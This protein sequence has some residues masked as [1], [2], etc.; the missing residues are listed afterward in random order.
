MSEKAGRRPIRVLV[1]VPGI[2]CHERAAW[3]ITDVLKRA[4][5]EVIYL[6]CY[7]TPEKIATTAI[8]EDVDVIALSYALDNCYLEYFPRVV[9]LLEEKKAGDI[10]V[11]GGGHIAED[12]KPLLAKMNISGLY[13]P[14][15][16]M[17]EIIRHIQERAGTRG[18][19]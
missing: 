14:G 7:N 4:G 11:V 8:Q 6:G 19:S 12:H 5:M 10:P 15:T 9:K 3:V 18:I 16:P 17:D 1:A 13:G 2:D